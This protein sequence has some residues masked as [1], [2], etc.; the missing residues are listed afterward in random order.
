MKRE[1]STWSTVRV[2]GFTTQKLLGT[3][4]P[5]MRHEPENLEIMARDL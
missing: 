2:Q 1:S 5:W 3:P 4:K